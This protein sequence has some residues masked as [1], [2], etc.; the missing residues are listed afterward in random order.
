LIWA[1]KRWVW[2]SG[3]RPVRRVI[4]EGHAS[5]LGTSGL[6]LRAVCSRVTDPAERRERFEEF[7]CVETLGYMIGVQSASEMTNR[8]QSSKVL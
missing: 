3:I 7:A 6:L 4:S 5:L 2:Y 8:E 1:A